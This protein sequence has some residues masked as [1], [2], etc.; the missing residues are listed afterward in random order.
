[1]SMWSARKPV[2]TGLLNVSVMLISAKSL[3]GF[4]RDGRLGLLLQ[5]GQQGPR[6]RTGGSRILSGDQLAIADNMDAPVRGLREH[7]AELQHF[8]LDQERHHL[9]EPYRFLLAIGE[10]G[11]FLAV[12]EQ[13]AVRSLDVAQ[14]AGGVA[15]DADGLAGGDEGFD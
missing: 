7:G 3:R 4:R 15:D 2:A 13:L 5:R 11:D 8:V 9:G 6:S 10:A 12:H 14:R 1:M